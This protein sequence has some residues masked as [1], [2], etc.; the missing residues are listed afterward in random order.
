[1]VCFRENS[2]Q[3]MSILQ[4]TDV[5]DTA[6]AAAAVLGSVRGMQKSYSLLELFLQA[7]GVHQVH[8]YLAASGLSTD[9]SM[10]SFVDLLSKLMYPS[11]SSHVGSLA[12]FT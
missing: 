11:I 6:A 5:S 1:M 10:L 12:F 9:N 7:T 4:L 2:I 8:R 3:R